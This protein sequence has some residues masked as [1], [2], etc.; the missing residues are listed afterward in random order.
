RGAQARPA[1]PTALGA[2]DAQAP[3]RNARRSRGGTPPARS[4]MDGRLLDRLDAVE[5]HID[6]WDGLAGEGRVPYWTPAWVLG[7]W[8]HARPDGARLR[9]AVAIDADELA[10]I[11]PC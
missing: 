10:G 7:W 9:V 3:H 5:A 6:A 11:A 1:S 2:H 4:V 8:K